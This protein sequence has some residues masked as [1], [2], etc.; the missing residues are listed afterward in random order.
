M[1]DSEKVQINFQ[2]TA[3]DA[4]AIDDAARQ[5]GFDNRSAW[6]R[7]IVRQELGRRA[8]AEIITS[9]TC[10]D[11]VPVVAVITASGGVA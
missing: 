2:T 11:G 1:A 7:R 3:E 10:S 4:A 9:L 8:N 5:D 6:I